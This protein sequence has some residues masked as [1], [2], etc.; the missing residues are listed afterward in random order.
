M[1]QK[2][3]KFCK[4]IQKVS[5]LRQKY[6]Q[7]PKKDLMKVFQLRSA[8][9]KRSPIIKITWPLLYNFRKFD[10]QGVKLNLKGIGDYLHRLNRFELSLTSWKRHTVT[11]KG[12]H[13]SKID[14]G[15]VFVTYALKHAAMS[16]MKRIFCL[17]LIWIPWIRL[18]IHTV[19]KLV[20]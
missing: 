11:K 6:M 14:A 15:S 4:I 16:W 9:K 18:L 19:P 20:N 8:Q 17:I 3:T 10:R 7:D 12:K 2:N 5:R 1:S 13:M